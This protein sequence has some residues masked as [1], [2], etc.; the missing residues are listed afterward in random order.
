MRLLLGELSIWR[1]NVNVK[2]YLGE[3]L[4]DNID[5]DVGA[6]TLGSSR[7]AVVLMSSSLS[8]LACR[9]ARGT[10][11]TAMEALCR[12]RHRR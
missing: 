8:R 6:Q 11:A 7:A 1:K 12:P 4:M 2:S 10:A 9:R 5:V 3:Q